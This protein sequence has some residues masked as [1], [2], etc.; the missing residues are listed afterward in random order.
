MVRRKYGDYNNPKNKY[1]KKLP[2]WNFF[3]DKK[4][5]SSRKAYFLT[6]VD[7][8]IFGEQQF[9]KN[10]LELGGHEL[11]TYFKD[12]IDKKDIQKNSKKRTRYL[13]SSYYNYVRDYKKDIEQEEFK[14]PV[15]SSNTFDFSGS[16]ESLED[17]E[18]VQHLLSMEDVKRILYHLFYTK[19]DYIYI[20]ISLLIYSGARVREIVQIECQN[21]DIENR[22]FLT[23]VKSSKSNKRIG[24]YFFP[25]FFSLDLQ[26]YFKKIQTTTPGSKFLFPGR[27][28]DGHISKRTIEAY[29]KNIKEELNLKS[30][31]N[32]H[33]F[34]DF[35]NSRR[36]EKGCTKVQRKFLLNQKNPDVNIN[37]YL[38][39]YKNRAYL[40]D[41]Y[42]I[43]NPFDKSIRPEPKLRIKREKNYD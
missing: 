42:D 5:I 21:I 3:R 34:R 26:N 29:L 37:S 8:A 13:I 19:T 24:L 11:L 6:L 20:A 40:R 32:P 25:Q 12:I 9:D 7:L 16:S 10:I 41:I 39:K 36:E 1:V 15:P 31:T 43:F 30:K 27:K 35:I 38:K 17:L 22:W 2:Y 28:K 23:E 18:Q 4:S 33:S 14:N